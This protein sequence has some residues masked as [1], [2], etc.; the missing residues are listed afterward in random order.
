M[1]ARPAAMSFLDFILIIL[2]LACAAG[3][4]LVLTPV[5][6]II[7]IAGNRSGGRSAEDERAPESIRSWRNRISV[8]T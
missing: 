5:M 2:I 8:E 4:L 7:H 3:A 1:L 6:L